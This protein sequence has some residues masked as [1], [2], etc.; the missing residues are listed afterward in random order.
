ML[1]WRGRSAARKEPLIANAN[2]DFVDLSPVSDAPAAA[3]KAAWSVLLP[4]QT[5][6]LIGER[7]VREE[8]NED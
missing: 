6:P 3:V 2:D 5:I 7:L 8:D 1:H 4:G